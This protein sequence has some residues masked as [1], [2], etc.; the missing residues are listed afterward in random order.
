MPTTAPRQ[1][2]PVDLNFEEDEE[3]TQ[4][5]RVMRAARNGFFLFLIESNYQPELRDRL[6]DCLQKDLAGEL[7]LRRMKLT[8]ANW[9]A[10][11]R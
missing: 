9:E 7:P 11:C 3:Y 8:A 4:L 2:S 1:S 5:L 10:S 6:L